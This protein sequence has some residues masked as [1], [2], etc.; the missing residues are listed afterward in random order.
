[1]K[2]R[3]PWSAGTRLA[4]EIQVKDWK[5]A[6]ASVTSLADIIFEE[7]AEKSFE[8]VKMRMLQILT[9]AQRASYSAG[10]N[11][12][13]L[14]KINMSFLDHMIKVQTPEILMKLVKS[15]IKN[16]IDLVPDRNLKHKK[17][18]DK[19]V[20]YIQKHCTEKITRTAVA[21]IIGYS[22][23][24]LSAMFSRLM[25]KTFKEIL[26]GCRMVLAKE[27]LQQSEKNVIEIAYELGYNDPNYFTYVFKKNVG[28]TPGQYRSRIPDRLI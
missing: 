13:K 26:L 7:S 5:S 12:D 21:K 16:F 3:Y 27:L 20:D 23:S 10:A 4:T 8:E 28:V 15:N 9:I 18:I 2:K 1:M 6:E 11:P 19:A 24:Y 25:G 22:P 14:F 17:S